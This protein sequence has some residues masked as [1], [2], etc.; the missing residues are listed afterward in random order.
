[1]QSHIYSYHLTPFKQ[2]CALLLV[3]SYSRVTFLKPPLD[4]SFVLVFL[5]LTSEGSDLSDF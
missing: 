5:N 1:M 4:L 3:K 2:S